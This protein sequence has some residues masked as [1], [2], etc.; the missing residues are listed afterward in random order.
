MRPV[1]VVVNGHPPYLSAINATYEALGGQSG[2]EEGA[3]LFFRL[4]GLPAH[5]P[6][7]TKFISLARRERHSLWAS[8]CHIP[9]M[10]RKKSSLVIPLRIVPAFSFALK[11]NSAAAWTGAY[12]HFPGNS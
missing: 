10:A 7:I 3:L 2:M 9:A 6:S 12:P 5:R 8:I 4:S 1:R 11:S